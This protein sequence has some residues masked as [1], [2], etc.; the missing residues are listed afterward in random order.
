MVIS[1]EDGG[2][3]SPGKLVLRERRKTSRPEEEGSYAGRGECWVKRVAHQ[4]LALTDPFHG[5]ETSEKRAFIHGGL[6]PDRI[7][8]LKWVALCGVKEQLS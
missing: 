2:G 7:H 3:I 6:N 1:V 8:V 5:I 4:T